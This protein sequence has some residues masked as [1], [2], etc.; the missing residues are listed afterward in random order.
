[1]EER[2]VNNDGMKFNLAVSYGARD[3]ITQ[4]CRRVA[5]DVSN[6]TLAQE[7]ITSQDVAKVNSHTH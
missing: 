1:M 4:A 3:D 7:E 2:T 5:H 6:G